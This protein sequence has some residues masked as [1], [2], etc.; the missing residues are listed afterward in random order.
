MAQVIRPED[1]NHN[2]ADKLRHR[3]TYDQMAAVVEALDGAPVLIETERQT[4]HA[5]E[6][7]LTRVS[8]GY[9]SGGSVLAVL[10]DQDHG[11][12]FPL[13]KI[14]VIM[15]ARPFSRAKW[16]ALDLYRKAQRV[17]A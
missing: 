6:Y 14:G 3:W 1:F 4:G 5:W 15:D 17:T 2:T 8:A 12:W 16:D 11:T 7:R 10:E 13:Y 9:H